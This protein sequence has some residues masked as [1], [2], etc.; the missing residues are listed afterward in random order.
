VAL[1]LDGST[2]AKATA[3]TLSVTTASFTPPA[4]SLVELLYTGNDGGLDISVASVTNTG[5]AI[6]WT[7]RARKNLNT[8][9]TGGVGT[10]A[11]AEI[12]TGDGDGGAITVTATGVG[13]GAGKEKFLQ[14]VVWTGADNTVFNV[15]AA[16]ST[17]GLPSVALAG[18][19]VGSYVTAVSSDWA[20]KG[21]GTAGSG[22][23]IISENNVA[24]QTTDHAWRTTAAL[25]AGGSQTMNLTAPSLQ[26]YNLCVLEIVEEPLF[27][28][29][30]VQIL[31]PVV[32]YP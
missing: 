14:A 20:Q 9:S 32:V 29:L 2:P 19:V 26:Q 25:G 21:L 31:S 15:A 8:G 17:G 4:G 10:E 28:S 23:T 24:G 6:T 1:A 11:G 22:Q 18:C 16:S 5:T 7:R 30:F 12:W 27:D 3:T 13:T